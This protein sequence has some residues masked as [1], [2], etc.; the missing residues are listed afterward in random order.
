M[1]THELKI[2]PQY[3]QA[4]WNGTKTFEIRKNDRDYQVGDVLVLKEWDGERFTGSALCVK[5][6]YILK[7]A[8]MYGLKDGYIIMGV[9]HIE[10]NS[11]FK[12][13][14]NFDKM[15]SMSVEEL[16]EWAWGVE[17]DGRAYG[18]RGKKAW[19]DWLRQEV[20]E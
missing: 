20:G 4:A 11:D 12:P 6:T 3:F 13:V 17:S 15:R 7:D 19:L 8:E 9:R 10:S 16:A 18:P 14:Q 2:L 1:K 5:V